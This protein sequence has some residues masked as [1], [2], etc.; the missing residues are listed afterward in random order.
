MAITQVGVATLSDELLAYIKEQIKTGTLAWNDLIDSPD[1]TGND[2]KFLQARSGGG[3][4]SMVWQDLP[5]AGLNW[6]TESTDFLADD[7]IGILASNGITITLP[8]A[9]IEG[10]LVA[11]ADHLSEFDANPV[12]VLG[13]GGLLIDGD[14]D[15]T[16]DL[17]NA[18]IQVIFD[19]TEW[20]LS[21]VNHPFNIQEITEESF[22]GGQTAYT[23]SRVP[24]NRSAVLVTN[25]GYVVP[26]SGYSLIGN[27]LSFGT[28]P[29]GTV[30]VRHI[31]VPAAISVSDTPVGAMLYFPNGEDIDGWLDCT[32]GSITRAVYPDLVTYLAK[33]PDADTAFLPDA[34]G[35]FVRTWDHGAGLDTVAPQT[36]PNYLKTNEWGKWLDTT[37]PG[38]AANLWDGS[39][40][41]RTTV[42][43]DQGYVGYRFDAPVTISQINITCNDAVSAQHLPTSIQLKA[44]TDGI[45]WIDASVPFSGNKQNV[46]VPL[47]STVSDAYRFWAVF[48]TGGVPYPGNTDYYWGVT[49]L[50]FTGSSTNRLVGGF[51]DQAVGPLNMTLNGA[52]AGAGQVASGTGA[53]VPLTGGAGTVGGGATETRPNNQAYVLR[54]KAFHYQSGA[55]TGTDVTALRGEVSRL[56]TRV[57]DGTSYVQA[58]AP[59]NPSENARWYDTTSGRTYIWF[60][61]QDSYQW[62][63]D[64]PQAA[65]SAQE[66]LNAAEILSVGSTTTRALN[67]RFA[68]IVN[69]LDFGAQRDSTD[70]S[71]AAFDSAGLGPIYIPYGSYEVSTGDYAGNIYF[72]FGPVTITGSATNIVIKD[73]LV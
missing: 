55:L 59:V 6:Q 66:S 36:I 30:F 56:S 31:G 67:E 43:V 11:V 39:T 44:S 40:V 48:G 42:R 23:L 5:A 2:G 61:D 71:K 4:S 51:Q 68:D 17:R 26:T 50:V 46:T 49:S 14:P 12:T 69:I 70:D 20:K 1:Y 7:K 35:N 3:S 16:L 73:L 25:N 62:V 53:T 13:S 52:A 9:P 47:T 60:N 37:E 29:V 45:T 58:D 72:S 38:T 28:A 15:L 32:G 41:S 27:Q 65:S 64:S 34:R 54:I 33:D 21:Q 24:P 10:T 57:N 18:Y 63:D 19:G 8:S 22:P